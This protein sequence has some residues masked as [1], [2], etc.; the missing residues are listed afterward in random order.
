MNPLNRDSLLSLHQYNVYASRLV[1]ETA[2]KMTAEEL[3]RPSSPSY[4]TV[5]GL[6]IHI[7]QVEVFFLG[8]CTGKNSLSRA[9]FSEV[10]P[11]AEIESAFARVADARAAYLETVSE[12]EL[13]EVIE[14]FIGGKPYRLP[15]WQLLAQSLLQS[16]HHRGELSIVM[17][18]LGYPLPTLDPI[19]Q[20]VSESGQVWGK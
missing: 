4:S 19:L 6:L 9:D 5:Q 14:A 18:S 8:L 17:T 13:K 2:A 1:L 10:I 20:Y 15:R 3:N 7:L 11:L 12:A 16:I